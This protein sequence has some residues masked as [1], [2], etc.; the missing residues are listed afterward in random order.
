MQV[1]RCWPA[2]HSWTMSNGHVPHADST[3]HWKIYTVILSPLG[4]KAVRIMLSAGW[5]S[6]IVQAVMAANIQKYVE[7]IGQNREAYCQHIM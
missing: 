1:G 5:L 4:L 3:A 6:A 7:Y 2:K